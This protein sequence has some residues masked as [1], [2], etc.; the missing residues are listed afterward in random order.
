MLGLA[1]VVLCGTVLTGSRAGGSAQ[2]QPVFRGGTDV[3]QV[4]VSVVDKRRQPVRGLTASDF[5]ILEDGKAQPV[6]AFAEVD[7][8][9]NPPVTT[10]WMRDVAPDVRT[11]A[12]ADAPDGRLIVLLIDDALIPGDAGTVA[13]AKK[14]AQSVVDHLGPRDQMAV[15]FSAE[16][17]NAQ[18]FTSDRARL[19][20]AVQKMNPGRATYYMGWDS[21][22]ID[23]RATAAQRNGPQGFRVAPPTIDQDMPWR[24]ASL[25]TLDSV[26]DAL[27]A[28][29]SR[30]KALFFVSPGIP[31]NPASAAPKLIHGTG[32][33]QPM[34]DADA[35]MLSELPEL[36]LRMQRANVAIYPI[37][38][39]GLGGIGPIIARQLDTLSSLHG[40]AR[41]PIDP[42]TG[43]P[44]P[45]TAPV[46]FDDVGHFVARNAIDFLEESASNTGGRAIVNL[47][48][49]EPEV[50]EIF[51]ETSSY[52]LLGYR[53]PASK[54][55]D[56]HRLS[57]KVD[58][59]GVETHTRS[60]FYSP[61]STDLESSTTAKAEV[62]RAVAS[63]LPSSGVPMALALAPIAKG[64]TA[65]VAVVVGFSEPLGDHSIAETID[66]EIVAATEDGQVRATTH[67]TVSANLAGSA[68]HKVV[69]YEAV[70]PIDLEP[71]RY[72][73]RAGAFRESDRASGSVVGDVDVPDFAS[74][75]VSL[76]GVMVTTRPPTPSSPADALQGIVDVIPTA[77]RAFDRSR[78]VSVFARIYQASK[79]PLTAVPLSVRVIDEHD[80]VVFDKSESF[81]VSQFD[82]STHALNYSLELP[83]SSMQDGEYLTTLQAGT[84]AVAVRRTV[85]FKVGGG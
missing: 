20:A 6:A 25:R 18:D 2:S 51:E 85:R 38:P 76:S 80:A 75:A 36:F 67:R 82:A 33:G 13:A 78:K 39:T 28:A 23:P 59:P 35:V 81:T 74:D 43:D 14:A 3:I 71:G 9:D 64:K 27:V 16:S 49:V 10:A 22:G 84:G 29:P 1:A 48:D 30:R 60:G 50:A 24:Q 44:P 66:L 37:D 11:N 52:Y 41:A 8:P 5:T 79:K 83:L 34:H 15:V 62:A 26:A 45:G 68:T 53:S 55:G 21:A 72:T 40:A 61:K 47:N 17:G 56:L 19:A 42:A 70:A 4:D 69:H 63:P 58:R 31:I 7:I 65:T 32:T 77:S 54:P 73:I 46:S 57:V 12:I